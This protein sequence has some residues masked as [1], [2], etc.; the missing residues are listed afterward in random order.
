MSSKVAYFIGGSQDLTKRV[1]PEEQAHRSRIAFPI[2]TKRFTPWEPIGPEEPVLA[3]HETYIL[4]GRVGR[5]HDILVF[6]HDPDY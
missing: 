2:I 1:I 6:V 4:M 5:N 3:K